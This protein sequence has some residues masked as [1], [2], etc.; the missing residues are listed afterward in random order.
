MIVPFLCLALYGF[1][2]SA[3]VQSNELLQND[4]VALNYALT[5]ENL[6][7]YFYNTY[8]NYTQIDYDN[9]GIRAKATYFKLIQ[10]H[11]NAHVTFLTG[12]IES[13]GAVAA[14]PW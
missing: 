3:Q 12:V 4:I 2:A 9:A 14:V 10:D 5:L 11:E 13:L 6:E 7:A 1:I 8:N